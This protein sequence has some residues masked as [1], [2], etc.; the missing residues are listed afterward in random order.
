MLGHLPLSFRVSPVSSEVVLSVKVPRAKA[1]LPA[2][3]T[4]SIGL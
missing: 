2:T 3:C 1:Q 4:S